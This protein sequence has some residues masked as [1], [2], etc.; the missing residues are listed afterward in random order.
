[1][2]T[3]L[4]IDQIEK[5]L[6]SLVRNRREQM[7]L[8]LQA[9]SDKAELSTAYLS[10]LE[11]GKNSPSLAAIIKL[12]GALDVDIDYFLKSPS[13]GSLV[14]RADSPINIEVDSPISYYQLDAGLKNKKLSALLIEI[15]PYCVSPMPRWQDVEE[16][17]Y[18]LNGELYVEVEEQEIDLRAGDCIHLNAQVWLS[19]GNLTEFPTRVIWAGTPPVFGI[20]EDP[21]DFTKAKT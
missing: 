19:A 2:T 1:M 16:F 3:T 8:T 18:V 21:G 13:P 14:H 5:S 10:Q 7:A 11:R 9:L 6:P 15:P 20:P 12:A 17:I 4:D